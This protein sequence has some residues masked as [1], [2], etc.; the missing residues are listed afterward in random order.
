MPDIG[1]KAPAFTLLNHVRQH[2][3]AGVKIAIQVNP[4]H[5]FPFFIADFGNRVADEDAG[6]VDQDVQTPVIV[7]HSL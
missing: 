6:T 3:P 7:L 4:Q 1:K 5:F 2:C